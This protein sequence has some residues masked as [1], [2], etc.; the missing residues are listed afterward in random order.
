[1]PQSLSQVWIRLVFSTK[2]RRPFLKDEPFR[3]EMFRMLSH[4][5]KESKCVNACVGGHIDHV[6]LLIGLSRTISIAKLV[7]NIKTETSKWAKTAV[8][9]TSRFSWQSGYG[10]FSVSHS[11]RGEV[12]EYIRNQNKHHDQLS[13]HDEFRAI[14]KRHDIEIDER[15]VWD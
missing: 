12:D 15:Y 7:E 3:E 2:E 9:G 14:C 4:H 6:H 8:G 5:V 13:F 11:E 1:M 10:V